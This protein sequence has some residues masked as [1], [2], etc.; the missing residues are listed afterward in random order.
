MASSLG[1]LIYNYRSIACNQLQIIVCSVQRLLFQMEVEV[2]QWQMVVR[3]C[4]F[5]MQK[6]RKALYQHVLQSSSALAQDETV[7]LFLS[8]GMLRSICWS[9]FEPLELH[10]S[11]LIPSHFATAMLTQHSAH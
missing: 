1:D 7:L 10:I 8:A 3:S 6:W 4:C 5:Y 2:A 11:F 9:W